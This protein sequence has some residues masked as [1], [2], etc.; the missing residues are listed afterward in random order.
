MALVLSRKDWVD[1]FPKAPVAVIDAFVAGAGSLDAA[2]ITGSRT[3]LAYALANVEHECGGFAIK[4]LTENIGYSAKRMAEV[5]PNRFANAAAV[6]A[7]YGTAKGWQKKAFD[8]IYGRRM[9]NRPGTDDGSRYIGRGGPQITGRDGYRQVGRR[10]GLD[11]VEAPELATLP[12][13]QPAILAAF[14]AWKDLNA[15]ADAGDFKAYVRRWN[16]GTNGLADRVERM[17]GNEPIIRRLT[18][19]VAMMP[20]LDTIAA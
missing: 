9:G 20:I 18:L 5:W 4:D 3:R 7:R 17:K 12:V 8:D 13:H 1:L 2:G 16:G 6:Q 15:L 14:V 10:A 11:L 19:A